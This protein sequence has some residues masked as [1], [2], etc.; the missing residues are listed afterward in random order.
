LLRTALF[1]QKV[2][3]SR[4]LTLTGRAANDRRGYKTPRMGI[5]SEGTRAL[6]REPTR[7]LSPYVEVPGLN[8]FRKISQSV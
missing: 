2:D 7:L 6:L 5:T 3:K 8:D 4:Q 1:D